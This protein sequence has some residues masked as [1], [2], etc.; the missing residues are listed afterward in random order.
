MTYPVSSEQGV[1]KINGVKKSICNLMIYHWKKIKSNL[2][3]FIVGLKNTFYFVWTK[4]TSVQH[5]KSVGKWAK[6]NIT[7][8]IV[9]KAKA[10]HKPVD[11]FYLF[12]NKLAFLV[13]LIFGFVWDL[14]VYTWHQET[15]Y[16]PNMILS[17]NISCAPHCKENNPQMCFF[18]LLHLI[19]LGWCCPPY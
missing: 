8:T 5:N 6:D 11:T 2:N 18:S 4:Q 19:I 12:N 15:F 3:I 17:D 9:Y 1:S 16:L 13:M 14:F 10:S 7:Y